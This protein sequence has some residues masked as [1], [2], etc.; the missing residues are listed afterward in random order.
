MVI[1]VVLKL[2]MWTSSMLFYLQTIFFV[3]FQLQKTLNNVFF[4]MFFEAGSGSALKS[5]LSV[6][7]IFLLLL[8]VNCKTISQCYR[9][10]CR[11]GVT[12]GIPM[13]WGRVLRRTRTRPWRTRAQI[14]T[15]RVTATPTSRNRTRTDLVGRVSLQQQQKRPNTEKLIFKSWIKLATS[16]HL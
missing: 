12:G 1:I 3:F 10:R 9:I 4:T 6:S 5:I 13:R 11:S 2:K 15:T 7:G 14:A 16:L 8:A